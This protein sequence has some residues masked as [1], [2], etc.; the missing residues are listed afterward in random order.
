MKQKF[1]KFWKATHSEHLA[2]KDWFRFVCVIGLSLL[3]IVPSVRHVMN[4]NSVSI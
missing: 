4:S 2:N 3:Y 1:S